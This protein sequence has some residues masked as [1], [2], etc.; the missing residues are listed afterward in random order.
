[1]Q[2]SSQL[3]QETVAVMMIPI[4]PA[5]EVQQFKVSLTEYQPLTPNENALWQ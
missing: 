1:M 5:A 2:Q 3:S 4:E